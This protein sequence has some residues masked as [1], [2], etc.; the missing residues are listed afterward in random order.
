ML[1]AAERCIVLVYHFTWPVLSWQLF[2]GFRNQEFEI[3]IVATGLFTAT[4]PWFEKWDFANITNI[5]YE[6]LWAGEVC[7]CF[8]TW[9]SSQGLIYDTVWYLAKKYLYLSAERE[10]LSLAIATNCEIP[11][12]YCLNFDLCIASYSIISGRANE[13]Q[14]T[15]KKKQARCRRTSWQSARFAPPPMSRKK[16][17]PTR[18]RKPVGPSAPSSPSS[19]S[20]CATSDGGVDLENNPQKYRTGAYECPIPYHQCSAFRT[21]LRLTDDNLSD[22]SSPSRAICTKK[23]KHNDLKVFSTTMPKYCPRTCPWQHARIP[24]SSGWGFRGGDGWEQDRGEG[25]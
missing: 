18:K 3:T 13:N 1:L 8:S 5:L 22:L 16:N 12:S 10:F 19:W 2:G 14:P 15:N 6:S 4:I 17:V 9:S 21:W 25:S 7:W 24:C 11:G 20:E 23:C